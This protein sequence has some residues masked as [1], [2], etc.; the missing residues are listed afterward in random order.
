MPHLTER[1]AKGFAGID[2]SARIPGAVIIEPTRSNRSYVCGMFRVRRKLSGVAQLSKL[3]RFALEAREAKRQFRDWINLTLVYTGARSF[4]SG[5]VFHLRT[6]P[7][8]VRVWEPVDVVS[9][10]GVCC[11]GEYSVMPDDRLIVDVGASVGVF[12]V[13]AASRARAA[14]VIA[15]EPVLQTYERLIEQVSQKGLEGRVHCR[16]AAI[17]GADTIR[18]IRVVADSVRSSFFPHLASAPSAEE[19][20]PTQPLESVVSEAGGQ[21]ISLLK[22]DCEGAE[23]EALDSADNNT[24]RRID[25]VSLEYHPMPGR[26]PDELVKRFLDAGFLLKARIKRPN[27]TGIMWFVRAEGNRR[28]RG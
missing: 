26:D 20:V 22:M 4:A 24:L 15:Y 23:W 17:G 25:R 6:V 28:T 13:Y 14:R 1:Y 5:M 18:T 12:S 10:W 9:V 11:R 27:L 19:H 2:A 16:R 8:T 21:R 3:F 7:T